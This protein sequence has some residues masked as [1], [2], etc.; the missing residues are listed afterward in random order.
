MADGHATMTRAAKH[1]RGDGW[2]CIGVAY[3]TR[4]GKPLLIWK[5]KRE[6]IGV[7]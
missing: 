6:W 4:S 7:V 1:Y 5:W 2:L 3:N